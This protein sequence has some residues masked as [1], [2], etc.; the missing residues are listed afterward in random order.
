MPAT[1]KQR[2]RR[3]KPRVVK[4]VTLAD[5]LDRSTGWLSL[6]L[7]KLQTEMGF[8]EKLPYV[9]G[10]DL[11]EVDKWLDGLSRKPANI[12]GKAELMKD[13]ENAPSFE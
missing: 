5:Y 10:W 4:Q 7:S 8:P 12:G 3:I 2:E 9:D 1:D 11:Q 6:H 13:W